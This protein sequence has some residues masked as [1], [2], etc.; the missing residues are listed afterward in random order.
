MPELD[1]SADAV[2]FVI[3]K[4]H[5]FHSRDDVMLPDDEEEESADMDSLEQFAADYSADPYYQ[6][7]TDTINDL[8]PD[9]Q[10]ALVALMWVGRGDYSLDE[11]EDAVSFAEDAWTD[12]TAEYL[13]STPLL[14]DYLAEGLQ[15]FET[16]EE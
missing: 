15:L 1:L 12:H 16:A 11:W 3:D 2:Q 5:E 7:L 9:Q 8:D 6:E 10:I 13:I 4:V 14:A